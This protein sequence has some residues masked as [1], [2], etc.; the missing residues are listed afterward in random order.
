MKCGRTR[1]EDIFSEAVAY[2]EQLYL[3]AFMAHCWAQAFYDL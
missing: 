2:T 3:L 1:G